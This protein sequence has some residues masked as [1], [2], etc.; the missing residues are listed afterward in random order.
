MKWMWIL[1]AALLLGG[2]GA[3]ETVETVA[4]VWAEP[5]MV[6]Q[7]NL[8]TQLPENTAS[9]VSDGDGGQWYECDGFD[10]GMQTLAAGDVGATVRSLTGFE[11]NA[12][13]VVETLQ[14]DCTRYDFIW[15]STGEQ[16][17]NVH[18][19]LILDDGNFH[20]CLT[21]SGEAEFAGEYKEVWQKIFDSA[22]L[23]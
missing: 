4:D 21:A 1:V 18:R 3:E 8:R 7:R 23:E 16:G 20:Y 9:P 6:V 2:C 15:V 10:V 22:Y 13:T 12:L 11:K 14:E 5:V 19:G 17:E